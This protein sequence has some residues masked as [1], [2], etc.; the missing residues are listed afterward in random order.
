MQYDSLAADLRAWLADNI[1]RGFDR[2]ALV[3]SL[4]AAGYQ[5]KFA[6]Q[7][8][9]LALARQ[10][11]GGSGHAVDVALL[12]RPAAAAAQ[13]VV[14]AAAQPAVSA[15]PPAGRETNEH[16][17]TSSEIIAQTSN[18]IDTGDRRVNILFALNAPRI[19]LFDGLLS[20]EECDELV[21]LSRAKLQRSTVVNAATGEY[22]VH[23]DRTSSG[24]HFQ[25]GENALI[26]RIEQR[27]AD[28][29]SCPVDHG[30][31]IQILHYTPGAE[32]KPHFDFFDPG[33]D[34]NEKVLAIV[35]PRKGNAVYFAY[36]TEDG[37]LDRRTL[38]GGSPVGAGEKW[39][40][41]KWLRQRP[42]TG[43]SA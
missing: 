22:D 7:A 6:R 11:A 43:P 30:E 37:Q 9:D 13:P 1:D 41:T 23:P 16:A 34:G 31:P 32:Y 38:H 17:L 24:T 26:R 36:T 40:A 5:P 33:Y 21:V 28:L 18:A 42:Y 3:Q 12:E 15:S 19:V 35:L 8:V 39:I 14:Q 27:I 25:R 20:R 4:R 10:P 29:V 2:D